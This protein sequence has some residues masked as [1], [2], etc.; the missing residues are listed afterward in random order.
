MADK[1]DAE[2]RVFGQM[3]QRY[4]ERARITQQEIADAAGL[5]KNYISS[6]ERG[7]H[8]CNVQTFITYAKKC[9]VSLD[10]MA[11]LI[12]PVSG[13]DTRLLRYISG[14]TKEEQERA[15]QVLTLMR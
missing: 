1:I 5:T 12:S 13:I 2:A 15:L 14:L 6:I 7:V 10:E 9:E 3:L 11:G 8:K 4:R